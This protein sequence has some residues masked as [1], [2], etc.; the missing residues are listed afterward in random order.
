[1]QGT[2]QVES[3]RG[4]EGVGGLRRKAIAWSGLALF[5]LVSCLLPGV[6]AFSTQE[7]PQF[8]VPPELDQESVLKEIKGIYKT[9]YAKAAKRSKAG[10]S[11]KCSLARSLL[12]AGYATKDDPPTSYTLLDESR[13][14]AVECGDVHL[15]IEAINLLI[16]RFD[17][18]PHE[19]QLETFQKLTL[20]VKLPDDSWALSNAV[21]TI[22]ADAIRRNDFENAQKLVKVAQKAVVRSGDKS[23][24]GTVGAQAKKIKILDKIYG[25]VEKRI[26]GLEGAER[27]LELGRYYA[28]SK[29]DWKMGLPLLQ[30][31]DAGTLG[32]LAASDA[33]TD[34]ESVDADGAAKMGDG[35]W[36][37]AEE[38]EEK[39]NL[40][41]ENLKLRA[42]FWY[43]RA[44]DGLVPLDQKRVS[45]RL[46]EIRKLTKGFSG[47]KESYAEGQVVALSFDPGA[48]SDE[49]EQKICRDLSGRG[50][51]G[52]LVGGKT[53]RGKIGGAL[54]LN[55]EGDRVVIAHTDELQ[56]ERGS[57]VCMW[58]TTG[59]SINSKPKETKVLFSKGYDE[60]LA[61]SLLF[62]DEGAGELAGVF[63]ERQYVASR[64]SSWPAGEW[65]HVTMTLSP[66]DENFVSR[67]YVNGKLADT[68]KLRVKPR[69]TLSS[70]S[71]GAMDAAGRRPFKGTIDEVAVWK[72]PLAAEEVLKLFQNS[73][74]GRSYCEEAS[75]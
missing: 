68:D 63:T 58:F 36:N 38:E 44:V 62:S 69:G 72:R 12:D 26:K 4:V 71:I 3:R 67:L 56:L 75:P 70:I 60:G 53:V 28:F 42:G 9:E 39:D 14:L 47:A 66:G 57:S 7:E 32:E 54:R 49:G 22:V 20:R 48:L 23:L 1:M 5:C 73:S 29:G 34:P 43:R 55:G 17:F 59:D 61:Y 64:R 65:F 52:S 41:E 50:H 8:P 51:H 46:A 30:K 31:G 27:D 24:A 35:W 15:S 11:A 33:A 10:I 40:S 16:D 13:R 6:P 74:R 2:R 37:I 18:Q 21:S 19:M 25:G 45:K